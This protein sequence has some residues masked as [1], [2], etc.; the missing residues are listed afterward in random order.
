[1]TKL[2]ILGVV[3]LCAVA[4]SSLLIYKFVD[5]PPNNEPA[6]TAP[7]NPDVQKI[8]QEATENR[9]ARKY[10]R[11]LA[12][13]IWF[14]ENASR[15]EPGMEGVRLSFALGDWADLAA[16][17]PPAMDALIAARDKAERNALNRSDAG[18][19]SA[20]FSEAASINYQLFSSSRTVE[21]FKQL[22]RDSPQAARA[23]YRYAQEALIEAKE[24][25]LCGKYIEPEKMFARIEQSHEETIAYAKANPNPN[26]TYDIS[27]VF[28][29]SAAQMVGLLALNNR[30][31]EAEQYA[32]RARTIVTSQ[33]FSEQLDLALK[34]QLP[35]QLK[36]EA[37]RTSIFSVIERL[38]GY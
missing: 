32:M 36:K 21:L 4:I 16:V 7:A 14:H 38:F 35:P 27:F 10:A 24:Y 23:G 20:G 29:Y 5:A 13:R 6:W 9:R 15:L 37:K 8:Y 22:D 2:K 31:R 1:M 33:P 25:A 34:G 30:Q 3:L 19:A 18:I 17:Y 12:Q 26:S 11:A 28:R